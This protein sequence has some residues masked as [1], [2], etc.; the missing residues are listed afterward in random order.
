VLRKSE[1][2]VV[3]AFLAAN[4]CF[5]PLH[6]PPVTLN[7][8]SL[9]QPLGP[10]SRRLSTDG[11]MHRALAET[12]AYEHAAI[13]VRLPS[14]PYHATCK[15]FN[16]VT[17]IQFRPRCPTAHETWT[18]DAYWLGNIGWVNNVY[19]LVTKLQSALHND[20]LLVTP[21]A[22]ENGGEQTRAK[23]LFYRSPMY[24]V[25]AGA[26]DAARRWTG[27]RAE[28]GTAGEWEAL[29][30]APTKSAREEGGLGPGYDWAAPWL[31]AWAARGVRPVHGTWGAWADRHECPS[32]AHFAF[33]PWA[34]HF[35]SLS[36]CN[37]VPE[38][39]S[40]V[41]TEGY[42]DDP[43]NGS[44]Y[45]TLLKGEIDADRR[46]YGDALQLKHLWE[47]SRLLTFLHRPNIFTRANLRNA[48]A[49]LAGVPAQKRWRKKT[50]KRPPSLAAPGGAMDGPCVG[51]HIRHGDSINDRRGAEKVDRSLA[52]HT[53]CA[54]RLM[55][56]LGASTV[57]LATDNNTLFSLAPRVYPHTSWYHQARVLKDYSGANFDH[58][59][60]R[61]ANREVANLLADM[62]L[63]TRC[64]GLVASYDGGLAHMFL[65]LACA[66]RSTGACPANL[67]LWEC[68]P[69]ARIN[70]TLYSFSTD[71]WL[72][73]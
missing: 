29:P 32:Q 7:D 4:P 46:T 54:Q 18:F 1:A 69:A 71:P 35:I 24:K 70:S 64:H 55:T 8:S 23:R 17:A 33:D 19:P 59:S 12:A 14:F 60:S 38:L 49:T 2:V 43:K 11:D 37:F 58:R 6:D 72:N 27:Q 62:A 34:C 65:L 3:D 28:V 67:D 40:V 5:L 57:F 48:L 44:A 30:E 15:L 51:I 9:L 31:A 66:R 56:D 52:A 50:G 45:L 20:R 16:A 25:K 22:Q 36:H 41:P 47:F 39:Q 21:R 26:A 73:V 63:I 13:F 61:S 42:A 10:V 53:A 68:Q